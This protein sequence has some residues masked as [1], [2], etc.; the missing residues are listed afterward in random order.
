MQYAKFTGVATLIYILY[1]PCTFEGLIHIHCSP[2]S[3]YLNLTLVVVVLLVLVV[4][5]KV[6]VVVKEE[7][8]VEVTVA[9]AVVV[10]VVV[11]VVVDGELCDLVLEVG[12]SQFRVHR[13]VLCVWSPVVRTL[14]LQ[15]YV[16]QCS[17][18]LQGSYS[19]SQPLHH[20][21]IGFSD[22]GVFEQFVNY[23]YTGDVPEEAINVP[24]VLLL[25]AS[26]KVIQLQQ[27]CEE[28]LKATLNIENMI[29]VHRLATKFSLKGL[30]VECLNF[31]RKHAADI[32]QT[33]EFRKLRPEQIN[34]FLGSERMLE[35]DPEIKLFLIISWLTEEVANRQQFLVILLSHIDWSVVAGDFLL[36]ISQTDNF[37]TCNPSSLYLLLQTLHSSSISLGPYE[38]QFEDLK[39]E[40]SY[41]LA[42]VVSSTVD[43]EP[44]LT[45]NFQ[46][47]SISLTSKHKDLGGSNKQNQSNNEDVNLY[48]TMPEPSS[49]KTV[50]EPRAKKSFPDV[51]QKNLKVS[52]NSSESSSKCPDRPTVS[53]VETSPLCGS[54][55]YPD[56]DD[57]EFDNN[58]DSPHTLSLSVPEN[59]V[60]KRKTRWSQ[61][62]LSSENEPVNTLVSSNR[63]QTRSVKK[64]PVDVNSSPSLMASKSKQISVKQ[65]KQRSPSNKRTNVELNHNN[66]ESPS[67][68]KKS[69]LITAKCTEEKESLAKTRSVRVKDTKG[70]SA[71]TDA[72]EKS[73]KAS[74]PTPQKQSVKEGKAKPVKATEKK[75]QNIQRPGLHEGNI[76]LACDLCSFTSKADLKYYRH[77]ATCHFAGPPHYCDEPGCQFTAP[78]IKELARHRTQHGDRR[79]FVCTICLQAFKAKTNLYA[80]IKVHFDLRQFVCPECGKS[81]KQ[82]STLDQ[83]MVIHSDLRPYLC[84]LCGFS[85][86]FQNHLILHKK[87]HSGE[88]FHCK[89][90]S[91]LYSTPKR[92]QLKAHMRTHLGIRT[93]VCSTCGK[94]FVEKSHLIRHERIHSS[95]RDYSCSECSYKS[96]RL[97]KLKEHQRKHHGS[98]G[99][100]PGAQ[101]KDYSLGGRGKIEVP[102]KK[103]KSAQTGKT[104]VPDLQSLLNNEDCRKAQNVMPEEDIVEVVV[105]KGNNRSKSS[106]NSKPNLVSN[107]NEGHS[108]FLGPNSQQQSSNVFGKKGEFSQGINSVV[109]TNQYFQRHE[110]ESLN[111][112]DILSVY[113][114]SLSSSQIQV[115]GQGEKKDM[116]SF[117][118]AD[119]HSNSNYSQNVHI[120]PEALHGVPI[121]EPLPDMMMAPLPVPLTMGTANPRDFQDHHTV[122]INSNSEN[123]H[124]INAER[125]LILDNFAEQPDSRHLQENFPFLFDYGPQPSQRF[126]I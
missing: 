20:V 118:F 71:N 2:F 58:T 87:I 64:R 78:C 55:Y 90:P 41:L 96:T 72:C 45:P 36:E 60:R 113:D 110:S 24:A 83:H 9:V 6:A 114:S 8:V 10:V 25:A 38:D 109:T 26:F 106:S 107:G 79:P 86:K 18:S 104:A 89:F 111:T 5:V 34:S 98:K 102:A 47:V 59:C 100:K 99:G 42:S 3:L 122:Y 62:L 125:Q 29:S 119:V 11:V 80:H 69:N 112:S 115:G 27:Y 108:S 75:P 22:A 65:Q 76:L 48:K 70:Q 21:Q 32:V 61:E 53:P 121:S 1:R 31:L 7:V 68:V 50:V 85:T 43:L 37:F 93:H 12:D 57:L 94:A 101:A 63:P 23:L 19:H 124:Y 126:P 54:G 82:K 95:D 116:A 51:N 120:P 33:H 81:F 56:A 28:L 30:E 49:E 35:M 84:D 14:L 39:S 44:S 77:L 15:P 105:M 92:T 17:A 103:K 13:L 97:D 16:V 4:V 73:E 52:K 123:M 46:P 40:Y 66:E 91:C 88:V 74:A 117:S 67:K